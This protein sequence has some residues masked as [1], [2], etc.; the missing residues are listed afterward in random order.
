[1]QSRVRTTHCY[2][3]AHPG[4]LAAMHSVQDIH[5]H[6]TWNAGRYIR[7]IC[8]SAMAPE[9]RLEAAGDALATRAVGIPARP[10]PAIVRRNAGGRERPDI[11]A[12]RLLVAMEATHACTAVRCDKSIGCAVLHCT[13][14]SM[15]MHEGVDRPVAGNSSLA[16]SLCRVLSA[17][18]DE[19]LRQQ[20]K[21]QRLKWANVVRQT[22]LEKRGAF[23]PLP[24]LDYCIAAA[25]THP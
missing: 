13:P 5:H 16:V 12:E 23:P 21:R 10:A 2:G 15:R 4:C 8:A 24:L 7:G 3:P 17:W 1:V 14:L 20:Y 25:S 19:M 18:R 22:L 11:A 9:A 6:I